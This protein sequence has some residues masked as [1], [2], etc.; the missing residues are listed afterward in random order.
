MVH[1]VYKIRNTYAIGS[2]TML[3]HTYLR[4]IPWIWPNMDNYLL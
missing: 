3:H 1:C 4:S 2:A